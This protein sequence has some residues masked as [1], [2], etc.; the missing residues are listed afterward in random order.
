M[1]IFRLASGE[2][3]RRPTLLHVHHAASHG[4]IDIQEFFQAVACP[5]GWDSRIN[6]LHLCREVK[7]CPGYDIKPCD[8]EAPILDI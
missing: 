4:S 8:G 5:L 3:C 2:V 1:R 7:L 6:W